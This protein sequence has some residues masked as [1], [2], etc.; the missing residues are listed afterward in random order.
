MEYL[1]A[2]ESSDF[3]LRDVKITSPDWSL[4]VGGEMLHPGMAAD[5]INPSVRQKGY[6]EI[7]KPGTAKK[8]KQDEEL[9]ITE[10]RSQIT[11]RIDGKT[12]TVIIV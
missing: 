3:R 11:V 10:S 9:E 5:Q 7:A 8:L 4:T 12:N 1:K 6:V 2:S